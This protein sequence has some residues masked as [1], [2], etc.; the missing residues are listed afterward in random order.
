VGIGCVA[1]LLLLPFDLTT[2]DTLDTTI[3]GFVATFCFAYA[4]YKL[5]RW[6]NRRDE[7]QGVNPYGPTSDAPPESK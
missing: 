1:L 6:V 3:G 4:V 2:S 7:P 5:V